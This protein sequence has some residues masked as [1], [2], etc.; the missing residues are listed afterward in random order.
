MFVAPT[1]AV[2]LVGRHALGVT[3]IGAVQ[4]FKV[5]G[6]ASFAPFSGAPQK[7]SNNGSS[8]SYAPT[9]PPASAGRT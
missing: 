4:W 2:K 3:A 5:E 7:L 1:Y 9:T 8:W 6:V